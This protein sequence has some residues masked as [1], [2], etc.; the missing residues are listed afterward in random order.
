MSSKLLIKSAINF[1]F[2]RVCN[3]ECKFCFH[4]KKSSFL[5]SLENQIKLIKILRDAGAE[6]INFAGGEPFLFP[7]ILGEMVKASKEMGYDS[8]SIISNGSKIKTDWLVKYGKWLD[9]LG[10]SCDTI[11]PEINFKHGRKISGSAVVKDEREK[12]KNISKT[13]KEM[14]ILFKINTVVTKLNKNEIISEFINEVYP[15]RW[16]IF[17]VLDIEGENYNNENKKSA[18]SIDDLLITNEEFDLYI[19]RNLQNLKHK[20]ILVKESNDLMRTSYILIDEY[21]R[22]LDCSKGGKIPT[23][24]I[25][26]VGL[27][28]AI[29]ELMI[30]DGKG[31]HKDLFYKRGGYYPEKWSKQ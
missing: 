19:N 8:T 7:E 14:N 13:C 23:N 6:K 9:I 2:T 30:N 12:I 15:M 22:F 10:I 1:H 29:E 26:E 16:K 20:E 27:E 28:R 11:S 17:Q 31:F 18:T 3:Y 5:L 24:S 21:G 4:T 25:L